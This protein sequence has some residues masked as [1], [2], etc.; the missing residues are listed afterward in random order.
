MVVQITATAAISGANIANAAVRAA[1]VSNVGLIN[2]CVKQRD[3]HINGS[4]N[5]NNG[6]K[7]LIWC[8]MLCWR[9]CKSAAVLV[10][11]VHGAAIA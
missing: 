10:V 6:D 11:S 9:R 1:I 8:R 4:S 3:Q 7:Q 5:A 2:K